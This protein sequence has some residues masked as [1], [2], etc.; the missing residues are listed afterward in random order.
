MPYTCG[1]ILNGVEFLSKYY[2]YTYD[3]S[4]YIAYHKLKVGVPCYGL[5][6]V[7]SSLFS[8]LECGWLNTSVVSEVIQ[9]ND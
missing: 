6:V 7:E 8:T 2:I 5:W 3:S 4:K 9:V 1:V